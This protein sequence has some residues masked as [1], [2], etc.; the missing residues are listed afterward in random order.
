MD[1]NDNG[2]LFHNYFKIVYNLYID[3]NKSASNENKTEV[4][5]L[6]DTGAVVS[7]VSNELIKRL[8]PKQS[9]RTAWIDGYNDPAKG[10]FFDIYFS[11]DFVLKNIILFPRPPYVDDELLIGMDILTQGDLILSNYNNQTSIAFRKPSQQICF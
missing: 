6:I 10:F 11:D 3:I 7:C 9:N 8:R 5:A 2:K 4:K 1:N